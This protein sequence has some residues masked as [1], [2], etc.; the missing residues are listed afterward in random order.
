MSTDSPVSHNS[1]SIV[2]STPVTSNTVTPI[3]SN[4]TDTYTQS[5]NGD[6]GSSVGI[7]VGC[8]VGVVLCI[9]LL[10]VVILLWWYLRRRKG[11]LTVS[12]G[13]GE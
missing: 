12:Q 6:D 11:K 13:E 1:S 10:L 3:V 2:I 8:V 9:T 4:A 7:I 5:G